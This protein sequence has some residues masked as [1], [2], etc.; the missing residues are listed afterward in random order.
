MLRLSSRKQEIHSRD[1]RP[2]TRRSGVGSAGAIAWH[3]RSENSGINPALSTISH[4]LSDKSPSNLIFDLAKSIIDL[5]GARFH[6][7]HSRIERSRYFRSLSFRRAIHN[8]GNSCC[9]VE[10]CIELHFATCTVVTGFHKG[11]RMFLRQA[12][13]CITERARV[14]LFRRASWFNLNKKLTPT[15][16]AKIQ[17]PANQ[18]IMN[19]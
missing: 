11:S 2:E 19:D 5:C 10:Q 17:C 6:L 15:L 9:A 18:V 3:Y 8:I 4:C 7:A 12:A 16:P 1:T 14:Q 13:I